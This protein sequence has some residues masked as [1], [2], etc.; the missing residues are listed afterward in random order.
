MDQTIDQVEQRIVQARQRLAS[1]F[2]D[3]EAKVDNAKD[4]RGHVA[5]RPYLWLGAAFVAG[6]ALS[7]GNGRG[8]GG[9]ARVLK[10][11]TGTETVDKFVGALT[12]LAV[13]RAKDYLETRLPGFSQ[14]FDG[15]HR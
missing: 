5:N 4:W 12:A 15:G 3:L 9:V 11:Q 10:A 7:G 6:F 13:T 8:S 14:A 2:Q 1:N